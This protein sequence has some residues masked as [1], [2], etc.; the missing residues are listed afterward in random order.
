MGELKKRL[1]SVYNGGLTREHFLFYEMRTTAK[2]LC[3]GLSD[4]DVIE[5]IISGN[6][7]QY[8]TEKS[9]K[10]IAKG[11]IKRLKSMDDINL[12][13]AIA[14]QPATVSKQICLYAMMKYNRI[15]WDFMLTVIAEKYRVQDFSFGKK[16]LN[17]FFIRLQEQD[18]GV[19]SWSDSTIEKIKSVLRKTL[20]ENEYLDNSKSENL[21]PTLICSVLE[22]AIR[23]SGNNLALPAF[24]CFN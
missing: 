13:R 19:A 5:K 20:V 21:N 10:L 18:D 24:N 12:V 3:E 2:L 7:Y 4:E 17:M 8:P 6:L 14:E 1:S 15:V 11:C 9:L 16:D 23:S 22:N